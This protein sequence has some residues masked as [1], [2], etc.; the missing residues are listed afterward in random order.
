M[1]DKHG[2][3]FLDYFLIGRELLI[4]VRIRKKLMYTYIQTFSYFF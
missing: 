1:S 2:D 4:L 3:D